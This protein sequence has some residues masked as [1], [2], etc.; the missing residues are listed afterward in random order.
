MADPIQ[1]ARTDLR[2]MLRNAKEAHPGLLLQRGWTKHDDN[3]KEGKSQHIRRICDLPAPDI[4][5]PAYDRWE[6]TTSN[7]TRFL[8]IPMK[9]DTRLLIG[10]T[11]GGA[12]ETGCAVSHT[13]G[14]PYIPGSSVKGAVR[15]FT[16]KLPNINKAALKLIFGSEPD[17]DDKLGLSGGIG[18]HDAW[19]IPEPGKKPFVADIVTTHHPDYY[20]NEGA[21]PATDLD[22]PVP[23][24]LIGVQGAFL[25]VLEGDPAWLKAAGELLKKALSENGIGAKTAAGYGYLSFDEEAAKKQQD[26]AR[27]AQNAQNFTPAKLKLTSGSKEITAYFGD[28]KSTA[29]VKGQ[30]AERLL[31]ALPEEQRNGKKIKNGELKVEIRYGEE[32]GKLLKLL[33]IRL[34]SQ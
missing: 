22:S 16:E 29:P 34:P 26:D 20:Q 27:K 9:I 33:E 32:G 28:K 17:E 5:K 2:D 6:K 19:W 10:L 21:T 25:L 31:A 7:P 8:Q 15:A 12:L 4:Y 1:L 13:Y 24:G 18:F 3:D 14:M 23:N 30:E 11:S